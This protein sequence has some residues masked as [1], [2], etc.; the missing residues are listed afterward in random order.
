MNY[1]H[2]LPNLIVGSVPQDAEDVEYLRNHLGVTAILNLQE[3][4]VLHATRTNTS[5]AARCLCFTLWYA[6]GVSDVSPVRE[7]VV[8]SSVL[9]I[10]KWGVAPVFAGLAQVQ[11]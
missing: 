8:R 10:N 7:R 5:S 2:I 11:D 4:K 3:E 6:D 1:S 9:I